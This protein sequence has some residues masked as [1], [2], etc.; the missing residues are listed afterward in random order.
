MSEFM[1][2]EIREAAKRHAAEMYAE[3]GFTD[4]VLSLEKFEL[5]F[6]SGF[7]LGAQWR[8]RDTLAAIEK[9]EKMGLLS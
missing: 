3:A 4:L 8:D 5:I 1:K 2:E 6:S 7:V 9:L